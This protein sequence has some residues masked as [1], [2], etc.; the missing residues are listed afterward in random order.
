MTEEISKERLQKINH[1]IKNGVIEVEQKPEKDRDLFW[2]DESNQKQE[3]LM[4]K[5]FKRS[6]KPY[7]NSRI[8]RRN[9]LWNISYTGVK[10]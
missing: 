3:S 7:T 2:N 5:H 6:I 8:K 4:S 1:L 10:S 9:S